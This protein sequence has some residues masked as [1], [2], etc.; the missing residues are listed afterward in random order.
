MLL[1]LLVVL[2]FQG[3]KC[4]W[5]AAECHKPTNSVAIA[6]GAGVPGS[7]LVTSSDMIGYWLSQYLAFQNRVDKRFEFIK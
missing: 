2:K 6:R 3:S 1:R 4:H 7:K 5:L